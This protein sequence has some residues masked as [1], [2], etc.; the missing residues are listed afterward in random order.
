MGTLYIDRKDI[1]IRVDGD[2]LVFYAGGRRDGSAPVKPLKRVVVCGRAILETPVL[3]KLAAENVSVLF[4][5][6]KGL[7]FRGMLHGRLHNNG[8][9]RVRQYEK[10]LSPF[11]GMFARRI[12]MEKLFVQRA[13]LQET[14]GERRGDRRKLIRGIEIIGK[15]VE[16][17][18]DSERL[19]VDRLR[20]L[21]GGAAAA[22]FAAYSSLFP[23]SLGFKGRN[24]RPPTDPVNALLS[25]TYT[26]LHYETVREIEVAGLDPT[27][28]FYH[29]FDYGRESLACDLVEPLR[30]V[31]DRW[32]REIFNDRAFTARDFAS[33]EE[34]AGCYLKKGGRRRYYALYEGWAS[35]VRRMIVEKVRNLAGEIMEGDGGKAAVS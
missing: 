8:I 21:E 20:G 5:S 1:E 23:E 19:P 6:G 27:I 3:H 25:L 29:G 35:A 18:M 15:A 12:I 14:A 31:A 22:Y 2:S 26:L 30:P 16:D 24:R 10:S 32:V 28:G 13:F 34:R 7:Q 9:L 33:G 17:V 4:L 11:A